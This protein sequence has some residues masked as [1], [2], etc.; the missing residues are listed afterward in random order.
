MTQLN[1]QIQNQMFHLVADE[2]SRLDFLS[3]LLSFY[4][5]LPFLFTQVISVVPLSGEAQVSSLLNC[6]KQQRPA[7]VLGT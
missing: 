5:L 3:V 6:T 1:M 7:C 2:V 4:L